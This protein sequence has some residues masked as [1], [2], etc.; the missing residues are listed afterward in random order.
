MKVLA[1]DTSS[2]VASVAIVDEQKVLGEYTINHK[3]THSQKLMPMIKETLSA[4][5]IDIADIDL[6]CVSI[7]PGSFTGLRIGVATAKA[8]AHSANKPVIGINTLDALAYGMPYFEGIICPI[9]DARNNQVYTAQYIWDINGPKL[10]TQYIAQDIQNIINELKDKKEKVIF[11]GD[12]VSVYKENIIDNLKELAVFSPVFST[13]QKASVVAEL[14]IQKYRERHFDNYLT[15]TPF[16]L[17]KSQAER[18]LETSNP[19]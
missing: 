9:I 7:G 19:T 6:Y 5:E 10:L 12:G 4:C 8:L 14:A 1:I 16:Y 18:V 2:I 11:V 15:L 3:K 13:M 17:R